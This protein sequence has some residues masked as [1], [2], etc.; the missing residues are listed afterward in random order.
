ML[1][2][3]DLFQELLGEFDPFKKKLDNLRNKGGDLIIHTSDPVEK[4]SVQKQLADV[5]KQWLS[6]QSQAAEKTQQL[7]QAE[8]LARDF[9]Q[10]VESLENWA[11]QAES[12][13]SSEPA[14][15]DFDRVK[16]QLKQHKVLSLDNLLA[17][18]Q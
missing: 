11:Q 7:Q 15:T 10:T 1:T 14:W 9:T 3:A 17:L 12:T 8:G 6:L 18:S 16:E 5:N 4:A 2:S 13:L